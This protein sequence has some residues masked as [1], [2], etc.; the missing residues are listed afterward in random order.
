MGLV[1]GSVVKEGVAQGD[2]EAAPIKE[3]TG[4]LVA[5]FIKGVE[6]REAVPQYEGQMKEGDTVA[7]GVEGAILNV[8]A[9]VRV[10]PPSTE[11]V[12]K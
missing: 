9:V 6:E 4:E 10:A 7:V 8:G 11:P 12:G 3:T 2:R 5:E 1:E